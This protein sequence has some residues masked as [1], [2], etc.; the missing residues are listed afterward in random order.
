[1]KGV[2]QIQPSSLQKTTPHP[3]KELHLRFKKRQLNFIGQGVESWD[4]ADLT[5]PVSIIL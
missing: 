2:E 5:R 3:S 1:M 4:G